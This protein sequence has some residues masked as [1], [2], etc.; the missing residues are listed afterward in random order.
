MDLFSCKQAKR[1]RLQEYWQ[2]F[3]HL[4]TRTSNITDEAVILAAVN[5]LWPGPCSSR[6]ARKPAKTIAELHKVMEKYGIADTYF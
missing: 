6:L 3:F 5:S 2:R 4:R 1:E